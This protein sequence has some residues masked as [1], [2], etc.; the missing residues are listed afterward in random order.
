M[1]KLSNLEGLIRTLGT[2]SIVSMVQELHESVSGGI[3]ALSGI[4]RK[5]NAVPVGGKDV[6]VRQGLASYAQ[7][8]LTQ[9][10]AQFALLNKGVG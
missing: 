3:S 7:T 1:S 4:M 10:K 9:I 5:I 6:Q 8:Q 2:S